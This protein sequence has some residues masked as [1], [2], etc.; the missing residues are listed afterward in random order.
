VSPR[1]YQNAGL[2][3]FSDPG[4]CVCGAENSKAHNCRKWVNEVV[5]KAKALGFLDDSQANAL[6]ALRA[7]GFEPDELAH[8]RKCDEPALHLVR[9]EIEGVAA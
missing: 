9:V 7:N 6:R 5:A 8:R 2:G 1:V 4:V 3:P